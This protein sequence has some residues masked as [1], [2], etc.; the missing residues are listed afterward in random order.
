MTLFDTANEL[1][2]RL[3]AASTADA[4]DDLLSRARIVRGDITS[5]ADHLEAVQLYRVA[6]DRTDALPL[7]TKS[8]RQAIGH[9]RGALS[10]SGPKALQQQSAATL[11]NFL[12][13]QARRI[14]RWVR[15]TWR[16]N[17]AAAEPLLERVDSGDLHGPA[18]ART[19]AQNR[20]SK[21]RDILNLNPAK[22][23][24]TLEAYL[25]A[26]G[27]DACIERVNELIEEL[28]TAI[29]AIDS[30]QAAMP[31]EVKTAFERAASEGGLPLGEVTPELMAAL[32][33]AGVL[34]DLVVRRL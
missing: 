9:L 21:I 7:N 14:D 31:Q 20:A 24:E 8:I 22:D 19:T 5:A 29:A 1:R 3:D 6:L 16:E 23:L 2:L 30:E 25:D 12:T 33:S 18:L 34:D 10:K 4:E 32:R 28:R 26:V 13:D 27:L 15:S 11:H 17:F